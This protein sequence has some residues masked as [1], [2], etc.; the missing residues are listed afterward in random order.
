M[1]YESH[2]P[3]YK[4]I[5]SPGQPPIIAIQDFRWGREIRIELYKWCEQYNLEYDNTFTTI[6]CN[7]DEDVV[8]F[9]LRW[10]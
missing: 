4:V 1:K 7:S 10:G 9:K 6:F 2:K 8:M 3:K 5:E